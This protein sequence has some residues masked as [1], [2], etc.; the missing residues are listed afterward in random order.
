MWGG[1]SDRNL[2]GTIIT[3]KYLALGGKTLKIICNPNPRWRAEGSC[4]K[5]CGQSGARQELESRAPDTQARFLFV[6]LINIF[7][8]GDS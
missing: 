2:S 1:G 4:P 3:R 6:H 5:Q 7:F 8:L